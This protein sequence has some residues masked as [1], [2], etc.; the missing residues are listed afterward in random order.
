[1]ATGRK[2]FRSRLI[3]DF[4]APLSSLDRLKGFITVA[5]SGATGIPEA[6]ISIEKCD[7]R[8]DSGKTIVLIQISADSEMEGW[9]RVSRLR[10]AVSDRDSVLN[11]VGHMKKVFAGASLHVFEPGVLREPNEKPAPVRYKEEAP[12]NPGLIPRPPLTSVPFAS[13]TV[14]D[15]TGRTVSPKHRLPVD[16]AHDPFDLVMIPAGARSPPDSP[17]REM[18]LHLPNPSKTDD[19][20]VDEV[21]KLELLDMRYLVAILNA[22][23]RTM[24]ESLST[25]FRKLNPHHESKA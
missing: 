17:K 3:F 19:Y 9:D 11:S 18:H 1:M 12:F 15:D 25:L 7:S 2:Q 4:P 16:S 6:D 8:H 20:E 10:K 13:S 24:P 5:L 14:M 22:P 23:K 21:S